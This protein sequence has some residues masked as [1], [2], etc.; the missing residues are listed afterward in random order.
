M[1]AD[2][3][4]KL[5]NNDEFPVALAKLRGWAEVEG[6]DAIR[7]MY[8]FRDFNIAFSFMMKVAEHARRLN[9][10]PT[11]INSYNKVDIV[12][13]THDLGGVSTLD[14]RLAHLIEEAADASVQQ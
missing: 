4:A 5:L 9:H 11:W 8:T 13:T 2:A 14:I 7:K 6:E 1:N 10:H 3:P 12:L